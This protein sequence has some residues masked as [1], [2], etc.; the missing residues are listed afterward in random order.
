[1]SAAAIPARLTQ[2]LA[3]IEHANR[4]DPHAWTL[5]GVTAPYELAYARCLSRWV[6]RLAP[7]ASEALRLAAAGQHLERWTIA[8]SQ[9]PMTRAGYLRW[10][11]VLKQFH[12]RRVGELLVQTGYTPAEIA[13]VQTLVLKKRP[14]SD[15]E[16]QTL[17]DALCL[18]FLERQFEDLRAKT[19]EDKMVDVLRKTWG[20]MSAGAQALA[21]TL[22]FSPA[23]RALVVRAT[24]P[25]SG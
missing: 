22:P 6:E 24:T 12:A 10:R 18:V 13:A 16:M 19:P 17:E 11:E 1:M 5:D 8:R 25:A 21:G 7:N 20:K 9:Y 14:L 3:L 2:A 15:P 23:G 4:A